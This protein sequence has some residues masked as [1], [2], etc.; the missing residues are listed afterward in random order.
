MPSVNISPHICSHL[1]KYAV[2]MLVQVALLFPVRS[3]LPGSGIP[4]STIINIS[5]HIFPKFPKPYRCRGADLGETAAAGAGQARR[6]GR[7]GMFQK[8][9]KGAY[10]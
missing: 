6:R 4:S 8:W 2:I 1:P 10:N 3:L 7:G 9:K 5:P